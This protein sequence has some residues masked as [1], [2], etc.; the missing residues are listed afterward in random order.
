MFMVKEEYANIK[1][2]LKL[3]LKLNIKGFVWLIVILSLIIFVSFS[4]NVVQILRG[5]GIIFYNMADFS[6]ALLVFVAGGFFVQMLMYK[7][8]NDMLS[9]FPQTNNSRFVSSLLCNFI[10]TFG[11]V[12]FVLAVFLIRHF[13]ILLLSVFVDNLY[14]ALDFSLSLM[15]VG[16]FVYV[17]YSLLLV[18]FF[19]LVGVILRKWTYYAILAF[20]AALSLIFA[21]MN[22]VVERLPYVF[23]FLTG[24]SSIILFFVKAIAILLA[25]NALSFFINNKTVYYKNHGSGLN[26]LV[27]IGCIVLTVLMVILPIILFNGALTLEVTSET[28]AFSRPQSIAA[29]R[30]GY[31]FRNVHEVRIDISHLP[32]GS[33]INVS[34]EDRD[35]SVDVVASMFMSNRAPIAITGYEDLQNIY[36][37][38][39]VIIFFPPSF[40]INSFQLSYFTSPQ[41][42]AYLDGNTLF[43]DAIMDDVQAVFLPVW[44]IARQF[45]VFQDRNIFREPMLG[46]SGGGN[47]TAHAWIRV[48]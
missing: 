48:E 27:V 25:M 26:K 13:V 7:S 29:G 33:N 47:I 20:T 10:V 31:F 1:N 2:L 12:G 44:G 42:V 9:V 41:Y 15:V 46:F 8:Q 34:I 32:D 22:T 21:N 39:I 3:R 36:G 16:F 4:E 18:S 40:E 6:I 19:E 30:S 5:D 24:E 17:I 14:F 38:T 45:D 43:L 28:Q 23:G 35:V 37:D 11:L